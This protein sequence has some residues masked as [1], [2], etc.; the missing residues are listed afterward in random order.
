MPQ[1]IDLARYCPN[2]IL[3]AELAAAIAAHVERV[4]VAALGDGTV[5]IVPR[6]VVLGLA[7]RCWKQ[8]ELLEREAEKA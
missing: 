2:P 1:P 3:R 8:N 6:S 4:I 7:E 5:D